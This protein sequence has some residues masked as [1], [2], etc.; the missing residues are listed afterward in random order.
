MEGVVMLPWSRLVLILLLTMVFILPQAALAQSGPDEIPADVVE[1]VVVAVHESD[2]VEVDI[3]GEPQLVELAGIVAPMTGE[4][5]GEE[6]RDE[7]SRLIR[8]DRT[9][10]I[11]FVTERAFLPPVYIW[12]VRGTENPQLESINE[13]M[14]RTGFA[15]ADPSDPDGRYAGWLEAAMEEAETTSAGLWVACAEPA[16]EE[17]DGPMSRGIGLARDAVGSRARTRQRGVAGHL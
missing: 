7:L 9:V 3:D 14:V 1:A 13:R 12:V 6:A 17:P 4:C 16:V 11:E 8:P 5:F 2:V 15:L 10:W